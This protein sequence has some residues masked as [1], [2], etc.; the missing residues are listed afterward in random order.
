[1][2][3]RGIIGLGLAHSGLAAGAAGAPGAG[4]SQKPIK[5]KGAGRKSTIQPCRGSQYEGSGPK[6]KKPGHA[7]RG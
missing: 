4:S 1:M 2:G 7:G 6:K 5:A 3:S